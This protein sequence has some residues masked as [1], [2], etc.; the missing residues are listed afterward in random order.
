MGKQLSGVG[1]LSVR[2]GWYMTATVVMPSG[3]PQGSALG[4]TLFLVFNNYLRNSMCNPCYFF[5]DVRVAGV[6]PEE[7]IEKAK[8]W[9]RLVTEPSQVSRADL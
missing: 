2:V 6:D 3:V 8:A 9:S 4:S 7:E 1:D 5:A